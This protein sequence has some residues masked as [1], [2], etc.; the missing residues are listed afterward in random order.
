MK[1]RSLFFTVLA[2]TALVSCSNDDVVDPGVQGPDMEMGNGYMSF[3]LKMPKSINS[4]ANGDLAVGTQKESKV[5]AALALLFDSN[6]KVVTAKTLSWTGLSASFADKSSDAFKVDT[7]ATKILVVANPTDAIMKIG[8]VNATL[9]TIKGALTIKNV[10]ELATTDKFVMSNYKLIDC[11]KFIVV[12]EVGDTENDIKQEA[13]DKPVEVPVDRLVAKVTLTVGSSLNE[14]AIVSVD[15]WALNVTNNKYLL[16]PDTCTVS[17]YAGVSN[18]A[19]VAKYLYTKDTNFGNSS[20]WDFKTYSAEYK[21]DNELQSLATSSSLYCTENTMQAVDQLHKY[22]TQAV[23]KVKFIPKKDVEGVALTDG[24]SWFRFEGR[25]YSAASIKAAALAA[26]DNS[27]LKKAAA[28][29]VKATK[30]TDFA[31][32]VDAVTEN[33]SVLVKNTGIEYFHH[34]YSYYQV[35]IRHN[36]YNDNIMTLGR[37]GVVRN[38]WYTLKVT[39]VSEAGSSYPKDPE[40]EI[41]TDETKDDSPSYISVKITV[42]PWTTWTQNVEL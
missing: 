19:E 38:N 33:T 8:K 7:T 28:A 4:R 14:N 42:K 26:A 41:F 20:S 34:G 22:T 25:T 18:A 29:F 6:D 10:S 3:K 11:K 39:S 16:L 35:M 40:T 12:G 13:M 24:D 27:A 17:D 1:L 5:E 9:A 15:G 31:A 36:E 32:A 37:Y 21:T 30:A 23:L 2:T